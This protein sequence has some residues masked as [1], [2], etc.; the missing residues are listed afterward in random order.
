V[1]DS[2]L[3]YLYKDGLANKCLD[4]S[5]LIMMFQTSYLEQVNQKMLVNGIT[6]EKGFS[7]NGFYEIPDCM[8][9]RVQ[10]MMVKVEKAQKEAR[11]KERWVKNDDMKKK[12]EEKKLTKGKK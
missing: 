8:T 7:L 4:S 11:N 10:R 12:K 5:R 2:V 3:Y 6:Y 1:T 9:G